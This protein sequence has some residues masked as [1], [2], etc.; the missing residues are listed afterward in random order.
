MMQARGV[1]AS[2]I[3]DSIE[4]AALTGAVPLPRLLEEGH[5]L[6]VVHADP[7]QNALLFAM[8]KNSKNHNDDN[9]NDE[10]IP[11]AWQSMH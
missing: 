1:P 6:L 5:S 8:L 3:N 9:L 7:L 10:L 11:R 4:V 2:N